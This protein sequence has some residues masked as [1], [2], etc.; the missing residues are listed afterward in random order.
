MDIRIRRVKLGDLFYVA[1]IEE[2][3]FG[4][5]AFPFYYLFELY[6]KCRDYF[7]VADYKGLT[8]G[9][10]VSCR[11]DKKLHVHS[12]AVIEGF[13]GK[14]IG[15]MLFEETIRQARARGIGVIFLEVSTRNDAAI[16]LYEKMGF[17][18]VGVRE[19]YYADGSDAYIYTLN[20]E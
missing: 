8:I 7:L 15:R 13:R 3:S 11:E 19:N 1:E 5:D 9:Y 14:G 10:I 2:R 6:V 16:R 17:R 20:L 12:V 18:R 4:L